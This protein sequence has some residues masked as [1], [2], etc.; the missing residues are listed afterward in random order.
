MNALYRPR[1]PAVAEPLPALGEAPAQ[2]TRRG[3]PPPPLRRPAHPVRPGPR[4]PQADPGRRRSRAALRD[5]LDPFALAQAIDRKIE[6][7]VTL[8][9]PARA[10]GV[11]T[12]TAARF[13]PIVP[14]PPTP[15][16]GRPPGA[17]GLHVWQPPT[18]AP[19]SA[20]EGYILDGATIHPSVSFLDGLTGRRRAA[21]RRGPTACHRRDSVRASTRRARRSAIA[22]T[23]SVLEGTYASTAAPG[24]A[25][26]SRRG[27]P[28]RR[29]RGRG[30]G[31]IERF[32]GSYVG[33]AVSESG[34]ELDKRD[35]S[36]EIS[37]QDKGFKVKFTVVLKRGKDKPRRDE[38]TIT[39]M[40][41]KRPTSTAPPC[42]PTCSGTRFR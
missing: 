34:D 6:Q 23:R 22:E 38:Y 28:A 24:G 36:A 33:E 7:L 5:Q 1:A 17:E 19:G 41:S 14:A 39:F 11:P 10:A 15:R 42:A 18:P 35:I 37:P 8:A 13:P 20:S 2:G 30:P 16:P 9:T 3:A 25:G 12:P 27:R 21:R 26:G 4:C 29:G 31:G 32:Y 40:P